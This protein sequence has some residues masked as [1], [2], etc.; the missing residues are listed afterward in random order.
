MQLM[1]TSDAA[2]ETGGFMLDLQHGI[3]ISIGYRNW[4]HIKIYTQIN[5]NALERV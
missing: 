1:S 5:A 2:D 3:S 4:K